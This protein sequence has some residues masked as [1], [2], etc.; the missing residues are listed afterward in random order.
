MKL[1]YSECSPD[2]LE[3]ET[4]ILIQNKMWWEKMSK[5]YNV[6]ACMLVSYNL[7][8]RTPFNKLCAHMC[9]RYQYM[10]SYYS[11]SLFIF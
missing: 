9:P 6:N 1:M 4:I 10:Y 7:H 2:I 11:R 8:M 3:S 5:T